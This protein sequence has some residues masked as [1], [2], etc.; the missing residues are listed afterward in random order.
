M[1][2]HSIKQLPRTGH[3]DSLCKHLNP[4]SCTRWCSYG[5]FLKVCFAIFLV[6]AGFGALS[7]VLDEAGGGWD[8]LVNAGIAIGLYT[9]VMVLMLILANDRDQGDHY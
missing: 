1:S 9:L 5:R 3:G 2:R 6:V 4:G 8:R 7:W